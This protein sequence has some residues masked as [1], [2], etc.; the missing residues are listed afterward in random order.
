[1]SVE[2]RKTKVL[3][4]EQTRGENKMFYYVQASN[5]NVIHRS[6]KGK[7]ADITE[8]PQDRPVFYLK[9]NEPVS[10]ETRERMRNCLGIGKKTGYTVVVESDSEFYPMGILESRFAPSRSGSTKLSCSATKIYDS[11]PTQWLAVIDSENKD[12]SYS[13]VRQDKSGNQYSRSIHSIPEW[14]KNISDEIKRLIRLCLKTNS[15]W[16]LD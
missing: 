6:A 2:S 7:V 11:K 10:E 1:M 15:W 9:I 12:N 8:V 13:I 4:G 3:E 5:L 16:E 14:E